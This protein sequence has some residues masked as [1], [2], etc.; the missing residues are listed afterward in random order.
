[1][2]Y[3]SVYDQNFRLVLT[4]INFLSI[5]H[6]L[7]LC[8]NFQQ[9]LNS[10]SGVCPHFPSTRQLCLLVYLLLRIMCMK[11]GTGET[12]PEWW[13]HIT[14]RGKQCTWTSAFVFTTFQKWNLAPFK[15]GK[16]TAGISWRRSSLIVARHTHNTT[17]RTHSIQPTLPCFSTWYSTK[18]SFITWSSTKSLE[19]HKKCKNKNIWDKMYSH[20]TADL[21]QGLLCGHTP[22]AMATLLPV[23]RRRLSH[24]P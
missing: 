12:G 7:H 4:I 23:R 10:C 24:V 5:I 14:I 19:N 16:A 17:V 8:W 21:Q 15:N 1:M 3:S 6:L 20:D 13:C 11:Q 9:T 2:V 22:A 18:K